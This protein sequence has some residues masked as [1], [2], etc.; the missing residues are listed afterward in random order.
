MLRPK[1]CCVKEKAAKHQDLWLLRILAEMHCCA[2]LW[3]GWADYKKAGRGA[4]CLCPLLRTPTLGNS[5]YSYSLFILPFPS[6]F[7]TF[8]Y[9]GNRLWPQSS[10]HSFDPRNTDPWKLSLFILSLKSLPYFHIPHISTLF[11]WSWG[12]WHWNYMS[13]HSLDHY[14][15]PSFHSTHFTFS[16]AFAECKTI[17]IDNVQLCETQI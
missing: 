15:I 8:H 5:L 11:I 1:C 14:S 3:G 6:Y 12:R 17:E 2:L 9:P 16:L 4:L 10:I 7:N 13:I